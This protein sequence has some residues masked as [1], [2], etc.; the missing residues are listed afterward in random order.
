MSYGPG[1]F[2]SRVVNLHQLELFYHVARSG[3]I[4]RAVRNIP[5]GI[6][7]P[8]VSIQVLAL[9]EHLGAKLF[10][11]QPFRLTAEGRELFDVARPLFEQIEAVEK[12]LLRKRSPLFRIAASEL[13]L[14][15]YLP[16]VM[17]EL[18]ALHPEMRFRLRSGMQGE[19]EA[20]L[21]DG[22]IDLAI[23]PL[24]TRPKAGV[25][26][27]ALAKLPLVLVVPENS[28]LKA[29]GDLW[30]K[31]VITE[32]LICLPAGETIAKAFHRGLRDLKVEWPVAIEASSSD[33]V[34]QYVANGYGVGVMV[35]LP[36]VRA[37][38]GVRVL[39][40][41]GF[42]EVEIVALWCEPTAPLH[43]EVREAVL[44]RARELFPA[45]GARK[46]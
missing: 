22:E 23:T 39:P 25:R 37:M 10:E 31:E 29:A 12:R 35:N 7:Q 32:S 38:R 27:V 40:L 19:M 3:G 15:D 28:P 46:T 4:S 20:W 45:P 21:A 5:Y 1:G 18:K 36:P 17:Q 24:D 16:V 41:D 6:Q 44:R 8:A 13:V 43:G 2:C 14:R 26:S 11:R 42:N 34:A 33:L 9:E 30:A